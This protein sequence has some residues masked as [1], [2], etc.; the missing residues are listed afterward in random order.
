MNWNWIVLPRGARWWR[1]RKP[2][3][4]ATKSFRLELLESRESPT[5][6]TWDLSGAALLESPGGFAQNSRVALVSDHFTSNNQPF[7]SPFPTAGASR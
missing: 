6:L 5:S 3:P 7:R 2:S 4:R 1:A